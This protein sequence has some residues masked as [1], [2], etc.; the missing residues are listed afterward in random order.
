MRTSLV[1]LAVL[2]MVGPWA[3]AQEAAPDSPAPQAGAPEALPP[4]APPASPAFEEPQGDVITLTT[5]AILKNVQVYRRSAKAFEIQVT[6][7]VVLKIPRKLIADVQYDDYEPSRGRAER[8]QPKKTDRLVGMKLKPE[9]HKKL[10]TPIPPPPLK[11]KDTDLVTILADLSKRV[12]VRIVVDKSVKLVPREE[13][14]WDIESKPQATLM[15]LLQ[16][17]MR[18]RFKQLVVVYQYDKILITTQP[19]AAEPAS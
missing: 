11:Y 13:L 4:P 6:E 14:I 18:K 19:K 9:V 10:T 1:L 3:A 8:P 5:G 2:L 15:T 17:E 7:E 12:G 16:E